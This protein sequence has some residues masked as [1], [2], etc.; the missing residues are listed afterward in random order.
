[1]IHLL[2]F[3]MMDYICL[4]GVQSIH[5]RLIWIGLNRP[6]DLAMHYMDETPLV[7]VLTLSAQNQI[8]NMVHGL[9]EEQA[10]ITDMRFRLASMFPYQIILRHDLRYMGVIGEGI[11]T[12]LLVGLILDER[13]QRLADYH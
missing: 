12:M 5:W 10:N 11:L 9:M 13:E 6:R 8:Q 3:L 1:M 7:A 2:D 4:D